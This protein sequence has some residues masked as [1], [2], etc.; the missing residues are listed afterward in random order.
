MIAFEFAG[1]LRKGIGREAGKS[2][3]FDK[4]PAGIYHQDDKEKASG[5][6]K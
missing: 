2:D 6:P 1:D 5:Q 4:N 3:F